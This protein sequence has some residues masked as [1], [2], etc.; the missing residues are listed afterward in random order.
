MK[1]I[2]KIL[3]L[4]FLVVF[5]VIQFVNRPVK[6]TTEEVTDTHIT[7]QLQI[8]ANVE[9][10]LKRSCYDCHSNHTTWPWYSSIAPAS[11]LL[12]D[13]VETGRKKMNFSEWTSLS[14]AKKE[15]RLNEICE[16][17]RADEMPLPAYLLL[18]GDAKLTPEE[19]DILCSWVETEIRKLEDEN[20]E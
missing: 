9:S 11:W 16:E 17:I 6:L 8:P 10:I 14:D 12:A 18:H 3:L 7:R 4:L 20:P 1:K 5:I 19:K 15:A 13:D 2:I